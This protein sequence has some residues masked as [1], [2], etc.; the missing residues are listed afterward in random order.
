MDVATFHKISA[1]F[2]AVSILG[3]TLFIYLA[4]KSTCYLVYYSVVRTH[5]KE[6]LLKKGTRCFHISLRKFKFPWT[7]VEPNQLI[8]D[9]YETEV[10]R[11]WRRYE[12]QGV[13]LDLEIPDRRTPYE[14]NSKV[15]NDWHRVL[16]NRETIHYCGQQN[17]K[18][19]EIC[20]NFNPGNINQKPTL[21]T[22]CKNFIHSRLA[23]TYEKCWDQQFVTYHYQPQIIRKTLLPESLK[24]ELLNLYYNCPYHRQFTGSTKFEEKHPIRFYIRTGT[25]V[26]EYI[27]KINEEEEIMNL[28]GIYGRTEVENMI[29]NILP[30]EQHHS[31]DYETILGQIHEHLY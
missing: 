8:R 10:I 30:P 11:E 2:F 1:V 21:K 25:E 24:D 31:L 7:P 22:L 18:T 12:A 29:K 15:F 26:F 13:I 9:I 4:I 23:L 19:R 17:T 3:V 20:R 27:R 6:V 28:N 14:H 5:P 16:N